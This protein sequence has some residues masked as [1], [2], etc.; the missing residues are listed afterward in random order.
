MLLFL[1]I[2]GGVAAV[3][4]IVA[5]LIALAQDRLLFPR[6]AMGPGSPLPPNAE[7]LVVSV[8][9]GEKLVG[10]HL[11]PEGERRGEADLILGFG[12]NAWNANDLALLLHAIFPDR[13][14]VAFHYRGYAPSTGAPS[15]RAI[16]ED[17]LVIHDRIVADLAPRK[18]VAV[19]LSLGAGPAAHLASRRPIG[20][21]ILVTPFDTL[22]ALAREHYPWLPVGLLLRH[23]MDVVGDLAKVTAPVA[24]ISAAA[25]TVI[26]PRRTAAVR[27]AARSQV[28]D[29]VIAHAGHNDIYDRIEFAHAMQQALSLIEAG[30]HSR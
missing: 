15:A 22:T 9:S 24:V 18:I 3:Y 19:G 5:A 7:R 1:K 2:A 27:T 26:P 30:G 25:D 11:P 21:L 10:V 20:G 8:A 23:R 13:D 6:W 14:V 4:L 28:L 12:G 17:A 16:L 29:R